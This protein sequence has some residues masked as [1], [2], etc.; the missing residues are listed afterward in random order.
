M[1]LDHFMVYLIFV[2][3]D[4]RYFMQI[5]IF[6]SSMSRLSYSKH[7]DIFEYFGKPENRYDNNITYI[8]FFSKFFSFFIGRES[9]YGYFDKKKEKK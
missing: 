1:Y 3:K 5:S 9:G 8:R 7:N 4:F 2:Q 6:L